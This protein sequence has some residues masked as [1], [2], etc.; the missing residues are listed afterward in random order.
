M[1]TADYESSKS[2]SEVESERESDTN[3]QAP[4]SMEEIALFRAMARREIG[5]KEKSFVVPRQ[6][7]I[8]SGESFD[9]E[10][11]IMEMELVHNKETS[12]ANRSNPA[13]ITKLV[14]YFKEKSAVQTWFKMWATSKQKSKAPLTWQGLVV[15]LREKHGAYEEPRKR[16]D[17]C[18]ELT[19]VNDIQ[20][21]IQ[22][23]A[24]SALL[25]PEMTPTLELYGFIKGLRDDFKSHVNLHTPKAL[26]EAIQHAIAFENSGA[27]ESTSRKKQKLSEPKNMQKV[28]NSQQRRKLDGEK[29]SD[30]MSKDGK[31][32]LNELR[33]IRKLGYCFKCGISKHS[34]SQ[35][36]AQDNL[37]KDFQSRIDALKKRINT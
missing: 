1:S 14:P 24:E 21:Y 32:A 23:K 33:A 34:V 25:C 3:V 20:S 7:P 18:Y 17:Q 29:P 35:C 22:A 13:F 6:H 12:K 8:F 2:G 10:P 15:A 5:I 36:N 30:N 19:Q 28:A 27:A 16:F 31:I 4:L 37:V 11:F 9:L 26:S